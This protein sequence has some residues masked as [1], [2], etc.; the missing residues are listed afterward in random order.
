MIEKPDGSWITPPRPGPIVLGYQTK[1]WKGVPWAVTNCVWIPVEVYVVEA[2]AKDP[3][4]AYGKTLYW[5]KKNGTS[6]FKE[7]TN[8][9]GEQ[10]KTAHFGFLW[11]R[12]WMGKPGGPK[13]SESEGTFWHFT[14]DK[15]RHATLY[16]GMS[17]RK[18]NTY[19]ICFLDPE[20][21]PGVFTLRHMRSM[22]K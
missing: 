9:A 16:D 3:Y 13:M 21:K 12:W 22:A 18:L 11:N 10:W 17:D 4:Y 6:V 14:D 7:I 2:I 19:P 20:L 15:L 8:R 5:I 1:D